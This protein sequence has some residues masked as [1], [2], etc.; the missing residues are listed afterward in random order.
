MNNLS[1]TS[2]KNT[3]P[4]SGI[5][6]D[7]TRGSTHDG[8]GLRTVVFTKG[9]PLSCKW[10]HNPECISPE[11]QTLLYPDKCIGCG[12]CDKGCFA[13]A[14]VKCG[15]EMTVAEVMESV[16]AD[17]GYYADKGGVTISGGEPM[18][19]RAFTGALVDA[20]KGEGIHTAV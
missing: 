16:L 6:T 1:V 17:R 4:V 14:K 10:C 8:P 9:C 3:A 19:Q 15:R 18:L 11:P 5:I 20:C 13:G 2:D 12:M 7:I